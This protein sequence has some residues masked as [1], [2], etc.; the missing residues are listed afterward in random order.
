MGLFK[1]LKLA[2]GFAL[3]GRT[4]KKQA[5]FIKEDVFR[6]KADLSVAK[7]KKP[8]QA[9]ADEWQSF[10]DRHGITSQ[11]L[12]N[13]YRV[14]RGIAALLLMA[15]ISCC[16]CIVVRGHVSVGLACFVIAGL[17]Y[18]RNN[19]RLYQIRHQQLCTITVFLKQARISFKECLPLALPDDWQLSDKQDKKNQSAGQSE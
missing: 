1:G 15:L 8:S 19:F 5:R 10:V 3:G 11:A 7:R 6:F 17:F 13:Q 9:Q 4:L 12:K 16:Y 18:F 2:V 14:R